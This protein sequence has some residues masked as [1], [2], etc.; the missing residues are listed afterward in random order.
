MQGSHHRRCFVASRFRPRRR[1]IL[2]ARLCVGLLAERVDRLLPASQCPNVTLQRFRYVISWSF[3]TIARHALRVSKRMASRRRLLTPACC[4]LYDSCKEMA[5]EETDTGAVD[6]A[7]RLRYGH[8]V[9]RH[10]RGG[11]AV[12]IHTRAAQHQAPT[13]NEVGLRRLGLLVALCSPT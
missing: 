2:P 3:K 9:T 4:L 8:N 1:L 10:A 13:A 12:L 6:S 11:G 5:W 7:C